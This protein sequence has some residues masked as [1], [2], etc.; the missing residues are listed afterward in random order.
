M[1]LMSL[2]EYNKEKIASFWG[3]NIPKRSYFLYFLE[4]II[5]KI[6]FKKV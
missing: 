2:K 4:K 3:E 6:S 1:R 5:K